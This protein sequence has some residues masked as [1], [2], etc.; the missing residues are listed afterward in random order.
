MY[1][2]A[3]QPPPSSHGYLV[4]APIID[5]RSYQQTPVPQAYERLTIKLPIQEYTT[6]KKEL[7]LIPFDPRLSNN[8]KFDSL[9]E[10]M[11]FISKHCQ[12]NHPYFTKQLARKYLD[13][14]RILDGPSGNYIV[15]N[16]VPKKEFDAAFHQV[17]QA[18]PDNPKKRV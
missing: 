3:Y 5:N 10:A 9:L 6:V 18:E 7:L 8:G 4:P 11:Y 17:K 12:V 1:Y 2:S 16:P 15:L 14:C 13:M